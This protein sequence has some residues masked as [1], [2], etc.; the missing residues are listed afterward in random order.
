MS[1]TNMTGSD[2]NDSTKNQNCDPKHTK[3]DVRKRVGE[4]L[5]KEREVSKK[6]RG[7]LVSVEDLRGEKKSVL[8]R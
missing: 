4:A 8:Q 6:K 5:K 7:D 3:E 1:P 2:N